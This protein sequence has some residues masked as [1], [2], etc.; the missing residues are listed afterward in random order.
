MSSTHQCV[1]CRLPVHVDN[2]KFVVVVSFYSLLTLLAVDVVHQVVEEVLRVVRERVD[3]VSTLRLNDL[4]LDEITDDC[5]WLTHALKGWRSGHQRHQPRQ[6]VD[7]ASVVDLPEDLVEVVAVP[8][9]VVG[10]VVEASNSAKV[11]VENISASL[12]KKFKDLISEHGQL[13][14]IS[15]KLFKMKSNK[16]NLSF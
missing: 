13:S 5:A 12:S 14:N 9:E 15:L 16:E 11:G 4:L 6:E 1:K 2:V 10:V 7:G 3:P 8:P